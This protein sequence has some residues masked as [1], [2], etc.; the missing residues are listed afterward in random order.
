[1]IEETALTLL[2]Q[3]H[4]KWTYVDFRYMLT[5]TFTNYKTCLSS[6]A[7]ILSNNFWFSSSSNFFDSSRPLISPWQNIIFQFTHRQRSCA[8][9]VSKQDYWLWLTLT[10]SNTIF[11]LYNVKIENC[12]QLWGNFCGIYDFGKCTCTGIKDMSEI[13]CRNQDHSYFPNFTMLCTEGLIWDTMFNI[14]DVMG[15]YRIKC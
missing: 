14:W 2:Y 11:L 5:E 6:S 12:S 4:K 8:Q 1:M 13:F 9:R 15:W 7:Q 10:K 3:R